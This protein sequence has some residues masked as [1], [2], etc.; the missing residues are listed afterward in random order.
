MNKKFIIYSVGK[1]LE[2]LAIILLVPAAIA[3][4]EI[5]DKVFPAVLLHQALFGLLLP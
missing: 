5:P 1:L 4:Y 2:V 3:F